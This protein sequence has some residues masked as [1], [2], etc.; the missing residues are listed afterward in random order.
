MSGD[1][2]ERGVI[3]FRMVKYDLFFKCWVKGVVVIPRPFT[4]N[5]LDRASRVNAGK[6]RVMDDATPG[7]SHVE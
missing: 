6:I 4:I 7:E 1:P 2:P 3:Y 5:D